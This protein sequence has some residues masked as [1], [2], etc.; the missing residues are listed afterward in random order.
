M[1]IA[2]FDAYEHHFF[3]N[4]DKAGFLHMRGKK[5]YTSYC[6]LRL[7]VTI[8][9]FSFFFLQSISGRTDESCLSN[10]LHLLSETSVA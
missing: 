6:L 10:F 7:R 2:D 1:E 9:N 4:R 8:K 3:S 5:K